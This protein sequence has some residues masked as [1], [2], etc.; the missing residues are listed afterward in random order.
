MGALLAAIWDT[1]PSSTIHAPVHSYYTELHCTLPLDFTP[2]LQVDPPPPPPLPLTQKV[3]CQILSNNPRH[4][5]LKPV[6]TSKRVFRRCRGVP[7]SGLGGFKELLVW[8][9][10]CHISEWQLHYTGVMNY[11]STCPAQYRWNSALVY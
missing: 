2:Y 5:S 6:L 9:L 1:S 11:N 3:G 4:T 10:K 7:V 8:S